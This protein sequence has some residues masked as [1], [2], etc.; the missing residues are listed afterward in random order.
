M[1]LA[2]GQKQRAV[3]ETSLFGN[4][5]TSSKSTEENLNNCQITAFEIKHLKLENLSTVDKSFLTMFL[6]S[7]SLWQNVISCLVIS[8]TI[9]QTQNQI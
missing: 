7:F 5:C 8:F 2:K 6:T 9:P 4:L 3:S 1:W